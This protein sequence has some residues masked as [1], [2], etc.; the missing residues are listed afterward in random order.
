MSE[1]ANIVVQEI[2]DTVVVIIGSV[3]N[4]VG[5][6]VT[7]PQ[8]AALNTAF[9]DEA[10][11]FTQNQIISWL[12]G[13]NTATL[14]GDRGEFIIKTKTATEEVDFVIS[15]TEDWIV[16]RDKLGSKEYDLGN[17]SEKFKE[18]FLSSYANVL[19]VKSVENDATK[20][21]ATNGSV[22]D[23]GEVNTIDSITSGE[24]TGSNQVVNLVSL[25]QA[26]YD[27]GTPIATTFYV[28]TDA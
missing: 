17:A 18:L 24:P 2:D 8:L 3:V 1:V 10:N 20:V 11:V 12:S 19:G 4:T 22:V 5:G 27:A 26:E 15:T 28:I 13:A 23:V 9:T 14:L 6:G 7:K 16:L 25:T 21:F